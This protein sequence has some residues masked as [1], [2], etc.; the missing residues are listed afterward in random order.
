MGNSAT[1]LAYFYISM[2]VAFLTTF[3]RLVVLF[4]PKKSLLLLRNETDEVTM[5]I[6][7]AS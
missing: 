3:L 4:P 1:I 5:K 7:T 6:L 2:L